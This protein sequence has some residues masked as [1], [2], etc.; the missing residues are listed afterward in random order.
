M[1]LAFL[2]LAVIGSILL[3]TVIAFYNKKDSSNMQ[4]ERRSAGYGRPVQSSATKSLESGDSATHKSP[5][6][7]SVSTADAKEKGGDKGRGFVPVI[8]K[9]GKIPGLREHELV[10][11][12]GSGALFFIETEL[13]PGEI[14]IDPDELTP[15]LAGD[16]VLTSKQII[17]FHEETAKKISISSVARHRFIDS[18][19]IIKR[20]RVKKKTDII[21]ITRRPVEFSYILH[22]LL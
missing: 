22:T 10:H 3:L 8:F 9:H 2:S 19:L 20:K 1:F 18:F 4:T 17:V 11:F 14:N 5:P 6:G 16:L 12:V 21:K 7:D 13:N 15:V